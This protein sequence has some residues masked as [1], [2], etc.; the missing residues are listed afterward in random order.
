[1][2]L[3]QSAA[4]F[5]LSFL[6]VLF[7]KYVHTGIVYIDMLYTYINLSVAPYIAGD[8]IRNVIIMVCLPLAV[9]AIPA[10]TY[11]LIKKKNM[12]YFLESVWILWLTF[13]LINVLIQ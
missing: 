5:V 4:Y 11:R 9:A 7:A 8:W 12:P 3:Q 1:M 2:L 10:L 13:I 6:A